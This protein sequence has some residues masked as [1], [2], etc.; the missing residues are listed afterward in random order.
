MS[1]RLALTCCALLLL[2]VGTAAAAAPRRVTIIAVFSPI[3]FCDSA[4]LNGQLVGS[5]QAGQ[6]VTLEQSAPPYSDWAQ[7]AQT[8]AD[9]RGYYS[10]T[11]QP[12]E[13][14][15]YR[16]SSQ[17]TTSGSTALVAVA[18]RITLT[19]Q[20]LASYQIRFSGSFAPGLLGETVAI[21]RRTP[22]GNW[23]TIT[24]AQ[25]HSGT[26]FLGRT[27]AQHPLTLRALYLGDDLHMRAVSKAV[28]V[29]PTPP[30]PRR[31]HRRT[32]R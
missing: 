3:T 18:P 9:S 19:A 21:Q 12:S 16:A 27:E 1:R 15:R 8:N 23:L 28:R 31:K 17:G 7:V 26:T 30:K 6:P 4:F 24:D 13:T 11:L 10:F 14:M 5:G 32:R 29:T 25:L 2:A 22:T 20:P